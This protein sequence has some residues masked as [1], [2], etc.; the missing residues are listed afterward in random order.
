MWRDSVIW[1]RQWHRCDQ[2]DQIRNFL[3]AIIIKILNKKDKK[4]KNSSVHSHL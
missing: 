2:K 1:S 3:G 4:N